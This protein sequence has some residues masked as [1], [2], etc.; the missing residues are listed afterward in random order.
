MNKHRISLTES[1]LQTLIFLA[2]QGADRFQSYMR[3]VQAQ[4]E[5]FDFSPVDLADSTLIAFSRGPKLIALLEEH[6]ALGPE[7]RYEEEEA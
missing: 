3:K 6:K 2:Q 4:P 5:K 7:L 1:Q